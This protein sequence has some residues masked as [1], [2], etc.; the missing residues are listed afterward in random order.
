[1]SFLIDRILA[2]G[3]DRGSFPQKEHDIRMKKCM[4]TQKIPL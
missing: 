2:S 3:E 1:M 4:D